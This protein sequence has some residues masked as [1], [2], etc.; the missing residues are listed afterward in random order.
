MSVLTNDSDPDQDILNITSVS[1]A[2]HGTVVV[3]DFENGIIQYCPEEGFCGTDSFTYYAIEA[4]TE[5]HYSDIATVY[6][7][8][9]CEAPKEKVPAILLFPLVDIERLT[10]SATGID[11]IVDGK[12]VANFGIVPGTQSLTAQVE[13]RGFVT[14]N[15]VMVRFEGLPKGVTYTL[16]PPSQKIKA[17]NIGTYGVTM[18]VSP[19]TPQG[20]YLIKAVAYTRRGTL[21][22]VEFNLI[23]D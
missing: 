11:I 19:D 18:T 6:I 22:Q 2:A 15:D 14:Q 13:N 21:D 7:D 4:D 10:L 23:V 12:V 8:V 17:H 16:T 3:L 20:T 1:D 9:I 5:E